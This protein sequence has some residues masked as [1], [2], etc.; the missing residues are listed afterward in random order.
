MNSDD[1]EEIKHRIRHNK[2]PVTPGK[3]FTV[4]NIGTD[5]LIGFTPLV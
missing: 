2:R 3:S 1:E 5:P 4:S